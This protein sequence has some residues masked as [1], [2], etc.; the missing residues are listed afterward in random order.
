M[1]LRNLILTLCLLLVAFAS[2]GQDH[3]L[4]MFVK[5][6]IAHMQINDANDAELV[7]SVL[8]SCGFAKIDIYAGSVNLKSKLN[9]TI[10]SWEKNS[11]ELT[12]PLTDFT[13][14]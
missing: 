14:S 6:G 4:K 7:D 2:N 10:F 11:I 9:W 3:K 12:K 5:N 8:V 1:K 13:G